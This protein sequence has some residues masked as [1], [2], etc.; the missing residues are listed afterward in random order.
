VSTLS[1]LYSRIL[2][3]CK[4]NLP[5]TSVYRQS[6]TA[7]VEHRLKI[8]EANQESPSEIEAQ[9]E[10]GQ[11]EELIVQAEQEL[12]LVEQMAKCKPWEPLEEQ[13]PENQWKPVQ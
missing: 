3:A 6:L 4:T 5:P 7:L 2:L 12:K 1:H 13:A 8:V 10:A 11:M 9:L